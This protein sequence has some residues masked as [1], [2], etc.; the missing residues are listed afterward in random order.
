MCA[1][2]AHTGA[3]IESW[4]AIFSPWE[5]PL[6]PGRSPCGYGQGS[7]LLVYTTGQ[8]C[9][10]NSLCGTRRISE[11]FTPLF[12]EQRG[13]FIENSIMPRSA[14]LYFFP[15]AC[16]LPSTGATAPQSN[17]PCQSPWGAVAAENRRYYLPVA[18]YAPVS[19]VHRAHPVAVAVCE[20]VAQAGA[21]LLSDSVCAS[22]PAGGYI[23]Y[24]YNHLPNCPKNIDA[25]P[26]SLAAR[27]AF[28]SLRIRCGL[29]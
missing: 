19:A 10:S 23:G 11:T 5:N 1:H 29:K 21:C 6:I 14:A 20:G 22:R 17:P 24:T 16:R 18:V 9:K 25:I 28:S 26:A 13:V 27:I 15:P 8:K 3:K 12:F 7:I 2:S 4:R